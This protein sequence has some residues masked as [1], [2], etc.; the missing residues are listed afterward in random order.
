MT[1]IPMHESLCKTIVLAK[2]RKKVPQGAQLK[3][4]NLCSEGLGKASQ[5]AKN[6]L[7][8]KQRDI[9]FEVF[10]RKNTLLAKE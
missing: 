2:N 10:V 8:C 1:L 3:D 7:S 5:Q 9:Y 6:I 4:E